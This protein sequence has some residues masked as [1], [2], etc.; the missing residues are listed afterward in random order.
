MNQPVKKYNVTSFEFRTEKINLYQV[1]QNNLNTFKT[2]SH[3]SCMITKETCKTAMERKFCGSF[4]DIFKNCM[5]N[6]HFSGKW[7]NRPT[8]I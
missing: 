7:Q 6:L 5:L 3:F 8:R 2:C 1:R 4:G